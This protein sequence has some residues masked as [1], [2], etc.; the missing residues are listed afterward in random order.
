MNLFVLLKY[1]IPEE[2]NILEGPPDRQF[3]YDVEACDLDSA[4]N[5]QIYYTFY[6]DDNTVQ[7]QYCKSSS[8]LQPCYLT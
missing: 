3:V 2:T 4:P 7:P 8:N 5:N 6:F 1:G